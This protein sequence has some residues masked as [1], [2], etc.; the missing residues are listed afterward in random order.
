MG[1]RVVFYLPA[2]IRVSF[3]LRGGLAVGRSKSVLRGLIGNLGGDWFSPGW[4]VVHITAQSEDIAGP[5]GFLWVII[6]NAVVI[7]TQHRQIRRVGGTSCFPRNEVVHLGIISRLI[8]SFPGT[9]G[10]LSTS[11]HALLKPG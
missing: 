6:V 7:S 8:T 3:V 4:D 11:H 5:G 1:V 2:G 9:G 10:M